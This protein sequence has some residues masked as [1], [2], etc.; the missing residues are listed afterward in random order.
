MAVFEFSAA[1]QQHEEGAE[2]GT[3]VARD[4]LEAFDKLKRRRLTDIRLRQLNGV[5]ALFKQFTADVR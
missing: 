3:V 1:S 5:N 2:T 4:K